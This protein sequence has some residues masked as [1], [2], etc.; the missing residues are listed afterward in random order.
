[1]EKN[2]ME[3][4]ISLSTYVP[5]YNGYKPRKEIE[6][7]LAKHVLVSE[8]YKYNDRFIFYLKQYK[9]RKDIKVRYN[10]SNYD[11][12]HAHSLFSNGSIAF[13][14]YKKYRIPY[15]VAVRST[16]INLFFKKFV[17]LRKR[18]IDILYHASK[19]I[20]LSESYRQECI[21]K[22][23]PKKIREEIFNK[24]VIIPNGIDDFWFD[25]KYNKTKTNIHNPIKIIFVGND[26]K[27]KNLRTLIKACEK[28]IENH[29]SLELNVVGD[30][31]ER[32]K[33]F[34][35]KQKYIKYLGYV[36]KEKL[37][38]IYRENDIFVLP[39]I[40]ETFGLVYPE[41]MSQGLPVIY[42][43]GQGFDQQFDDG[44]IGYSVNSRDACDIADKIIKIVQNYEDISHR[45]IKLVSKFNWKRIVKE[46][47]NIYQE[48]LTRKH[49]V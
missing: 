17:Y 1:M 49:S 44:L 15:V 42:S 3:L 24:S 47:E 12:L 46:Y 28:L 8:C 2:L 20:F 32:T 45:T 9:I 36:N 6:F 39:S 37:L 31:S 43:K 16:D 33:R 18:G 40:K 26:S 41:A 19:I 34:I 29:Y 25:N 48:V 21:E 22:Y 5:L 38:N 13:S 10:F 23:V 4:G 11:I 35:S 30:L 7:P 14:I 27:R